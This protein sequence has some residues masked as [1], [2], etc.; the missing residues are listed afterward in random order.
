[1]QSVISMKVKMMVGSMHIICMHTPSQ[2]LCICARYTC[3]QTLALQCMIES[4]ACDWSVNA[5]SKGKM[6]MISLALKMENLSIKSL[7]GELD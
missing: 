7:T 6:G 3:I 2:I 1:M 4:M 5:L